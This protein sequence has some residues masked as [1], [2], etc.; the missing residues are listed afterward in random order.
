MRTAAMLT[1]LLSLVLT[2]ALVAQ[3]LGDTLWTRTYGGYTDDYGYRSRQTTDGGYVLVGQ[4]K[5]FGA[6]SYDI[7]LLKLDADG[8]TLWTRTYGG[9]EYDVG[10]HV[11]QTDDGGYILGGYTRSVGAGGFDAYL[12]KTD[13]AGEVDWTCVWGDSLDET[14]S[15]V[16][17]TTDGGYIVSG[18]TQSFGPNGFM[19]AFLMKVEEG[20][21]ME[22]VRI[23]GGDPTDFG[24][25]VIQTPDEGYLLSG[26]CTKLLQ[27]QDVR[28]VWLVKTD[29]TGDT[30]WTRAYDV[31][32]GYDLGQ[33]IKATSDGGYIVAGWAE[34]SLGVDYDVLLLKL[35]ANGD[36]LWSRQYGGRRWDLGES[37]EQTSDGGYIVTGLANGISNVYDIWLLK[38]DA[39]GDTLWTRTYGGTGNDHAYSVRETTDGNYLISGYTDSFG[40]G[41]YDF[42][43]LKVV[44]I[45]IGVDPGEVILPTVTALHQNYPNP[46]N[47]STTI[48]FSLAE[49][50]NA[51]LRVYGLDGRLVAT[52]VRG[53]MEP[54]EHVI[55]WDASEVSS[56]VY[57]YKLTA[58]DYIDAKRMMLIK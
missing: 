44:G 52:L 15:C 17:Q 30:L 5:S 4:S 55:S 48:S 45:V 19:D 29:E 33:E 9:F 27:D 38:T 8:D 53:Q 36:S 12:V 32:D 2:S 20:G 13:E 22:W 26:F 57:F 56:G 28:S 40:T 41:G 10:I 16:T 46:F 34:V 37:V 23:Y 14:V 31:S 25:Y 50:G 18:N 6:G 49:H 51:T 1:L 35:D 43:V 11:E 54:G 39:N 7:W 3:E 24:R 42:Y 21:D 47:A 58:G